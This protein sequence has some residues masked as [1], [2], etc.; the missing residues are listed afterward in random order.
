MIAM[1]STP[2]LSYEIV[3]TSFYAVALNFFFFFGGG[4]DNE[5]LIL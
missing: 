4:G 1:K 2:F 3:S 5:D